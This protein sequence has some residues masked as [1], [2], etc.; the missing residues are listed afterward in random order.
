MGWAVCDLPDLHMGW[1]LHTGTYPN[2]KV[3]CPCYGL[4]VQIISSIHKLQFFLFFF[5]FFFKKKMI[6]I[7]KYTYMEQT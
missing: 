1:T 2:E 5:L 3:L 4:E 6:V 7:K